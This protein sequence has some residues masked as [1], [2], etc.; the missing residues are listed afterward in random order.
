MLQRLLFVP[1]HF[2]AARLSLSGLFG[3]FAAFGKSR[4]CAADLAQYASAFA[5]SGL[6]LGPPSF[7]GPAC[8]YDTFLPLA[9]ILTRALP[10]AGVLLLGIIIFPFSSP[11]WRFP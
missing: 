3:F 2:H 8:P 7:A 6:T 1:S 4:S 5:V 9:V 10:S 11:A